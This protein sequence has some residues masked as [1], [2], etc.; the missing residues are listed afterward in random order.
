ML[1]QMCVMEW[2]DLCLKI[3]ERRK[4]L[5]A[6]D[7]GASTETFCGQTSSFEF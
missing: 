3:A 1:L 5:V 7:G 6:S 4:V 2:I